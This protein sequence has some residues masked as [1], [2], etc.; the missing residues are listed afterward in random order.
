MFK[1]EYELPEGWHDMDQ[2]RSFECLKGKTVWNFQIDKEKENILF[3][4]T[5]NTIYL[6]YHEQECCE[7]VYVE[8]ICGHIT[9]ILNEPILKAE[10]RISRSEEVD[11]YGECNKSWTFYYL[12]TKKGSITIRWCGTSNGYYSETA[13]FIEL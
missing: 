3:F 7:Y 5:D 13:D 9:D 1:K 6:M 8:D 12:A 10:R 11:E 2:E 4:C